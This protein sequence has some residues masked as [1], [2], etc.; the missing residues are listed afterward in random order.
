MGNEVFESYVFDSDEWGKNTVYSKIF[1]WLGVIGIF[2]NVDGTSPTS[3]SI[4]DHLGVPFVFQNISLTV[5][6]IFLIASVLFMTKKKSKGMIRID[7]NKVQILG[8]VYDVAELKNLDVTI[9]QLDKGQTYGERSYKEG[10]KNFLS[11]KTA[12]GLQHHEF[13]IKTTV[14]EQKLRRIIGSWQNK[15]SA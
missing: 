9:N 2:S 12:K 4:Q 8:Q 10:G 15:T 3:M 5:G 14:E 7:S 1:G 13:Y 11:Y 6:I